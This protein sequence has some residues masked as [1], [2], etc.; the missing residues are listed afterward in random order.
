MLSMKSGSAN[1]KFGT[2]SYLCAGYYQYTIA[3]DQFEGYQ[4]ISSNWKETNTRCWP[5]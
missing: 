1:E 2:I 5:S 3:V 4:R